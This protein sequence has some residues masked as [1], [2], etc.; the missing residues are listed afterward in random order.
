MKANNSQLSQLEKENIDLKLMNISDRIT[1]MGE[2][3]T[4]KLDKILE[5]TTKTNGSVLDQRKRLE[6]LE[7]EK[8]VLEMKLKDLQGHF[9]NLEQDVKPIR[10]LL[11]TPK[12]VAAVSAW[13]LTYLFSIKEVRDVIFNLF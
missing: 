3:F 1:S 10:S 5:Q 2:E 8:I 7:K 12:I 4:Y 9:T 6:E 13:A 11:S